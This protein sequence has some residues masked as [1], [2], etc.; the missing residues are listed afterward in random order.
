MV[1]ME[2]IPGF[3]YTIDS[4]GTIG[5]GIPGDKNDVYHPN[6]KGYSKMSDVWFDALKAVLGT[7]PSII[8]QPIAQGAIEG[9]NVTFS[10]TVADTQG[11]RYQWFKDN[12]IINSA[13][14]STYEIPNVSLS[15]NG[16]VY[17]CEVYNLGA[18]VFS[19]EATLV[20]TG[21]DQRVTY[22]SQVLYYFNEGTGTAINDS[23]NVGSPLNLKIN[24]TDKVE[25]VPFGLKIKSGSSISSTSTASKIFNAC[26][27]SNEITIE[28]LILPSRLNQPGPARIITYSK[29]GNARNFTLSQDG[30]IFQTRLRTT[31]TTINGIPAISSSNPITQLNPL[32]VVYVH[33][34]DGTTKIYIN[35]VEEGNTNIGGDLSN[36]DNSYS[37]G[38]GNEF[39]DSRPWEGIIF[40]AS[41]F[42]RALSKA[43]IEHNYLIGKDG[44][45]EVN[46]PSNLNG[47]VNSSN[48]VELT[49]QD[50]SNTE[51]GFIIEGRPQIQDSV[52]SVIDTVTA[53]S[54]NYTDIKPKHFTPYQYRIIAYTDYIQSEPSDTT[55]VNVVS[56]PKTRST[57]PR[58]F[59]LS[60]NFPN[61]FNPTTTISYSIP[62]ESN[63]K[64][65]IYNS[66]GQVARELVNQS[67]GAGNYSVLFDAGNLS[68]GVYY[69][70]LSAISIEKKSKFADVKKLVL[71][72]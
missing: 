7:P 42:N 58:K 15:D 45:T 27:S 64:L 18:S 72:K 19:D 11:I 50:N 34:K 63:V 70:S 56:S 13:T 21:L 20:V 3:D 57:L 48:F 8:Q 49:W 38:I 47:V 33:R 66:I 12:V 37:L 26:T 68:S 22:G 54:T 32:H 25:W 17:K 39:I 23:S 29:N 67:Q 16:S 46:S 61:P 31:S 6:D 60:Q 14:S 2:N 28:T 1:N 5:D 36:W 65:I 41:I 53:N 55:T 9:D 51:G 4:M 10:V 40:Y 59:A 71:I 43:E 44:V 69:Y 35:G 62:V 30:T 52:F 24:L